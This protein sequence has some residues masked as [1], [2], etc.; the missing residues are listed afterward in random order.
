MEIRT[1]NSGWI[2][3]LVSGMVAITYGLLALLFSQEIIET[4]LL[5]LGIGSIIMGLLC[6][7]LSL[8]R[9]KKEL[10]WGMLLFEAIAMVALGVVSIIWPKEFTASLIFIIGL[11]SVLIGFLMLIAILR[12]KFLYNKA[13]YIVSAALSIVFG[14][15]LMVKPF[16]VGEVFIKV[17][18]VIALVFGII[19][20][21]FGFTLRKMDK[22]I[23][24][25]LID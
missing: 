2:T 15:L 3:F 9:K 21:M 18:G 6:L 25:E 23:K 5:F 1:S 10:P 13:F 20:M 17:T 4:I 22:D 14:V 12:F 19:M 24:V 8:K 11:W 16:E 7:W